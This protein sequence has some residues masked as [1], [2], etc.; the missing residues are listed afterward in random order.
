[1]NI[2]WVYPSF[3]LLIPLVLAL[4]LL[5]RHQHVRS[6]VARPKMKHLLASPSGVSKSVEPGTRARR[7]GGW[8]GLT[9]LCLAAVALARPQWG[10]TEQK[11][12][13]RSREV[14]IALDLS[15][16]MLATDVQPNR[17]DRAKLLVDSL[18]KELQGERIGLVVF[19]G[20][21]FVQCP[22][23]NDYE[24][25]RE[26]LKEVNPYF[27][28]QQGTDFGKLLQTAYK[29]FDFTSSSDRFLIVLSDGEDLAGDWEGQLKNYTDSKIH[30]ISLGVG[31]PGGSVIPEKNGGV[32]KDERGAV[33]LTRLDSRVLQE[34]ADKTSGRYVDAYR[35]VDLPKVL[36]ETVEQGEK[37]SFA[38]KNQVLKVERFQIPL[39]FALLFALLSLWRDFP[40]HPR[41]SIKKPSHLEKSLDRRL[42]R[43]ASS[44]PPIPAATA[45]LFLLALPLSLSA[46]QAPAQPAAGQ[47]APGEKLSGTVHTLAARDSLTPTDYAQLAEETI[48]YGKALQQ[49]KGNIEMGAVDDALLGV[50]E[51]EA[52]DAKAADWPRL[53]K[54]LEE[55]KKKASDQQKQKQDQQKQ[56]KQNKDKNQKQDQQKQNSGK[57]DQDKQNQQN[58]DPSQSDQNSG[59]E[60][61]DQNQKNQKDQESKNQDSKDQK[62]GQNGQDQQ[63]QDSQGQNRPEDE[64]D[65]NPNRN[66]NQEQGQDSKENKEKEDSK[67]QPKP[68][69]GSNEKKESQPETKKVGGGSSGQKAEK[70]EAPDAETAEMARKLD[71]IKEKDSPGKIY[72]LFSPQQ[73]SKEI[74]GKTW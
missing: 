69:S 51:G 41:H 47:P 46:Q 22:L 2:T 9:A 53:R 38:K 8:F 26:M 13:E 20:T 67:N 73:P 6:L 31:T 33:V 35:W 74:K 16:S 23:S 32:I 40:V 18:V 36:A 7:G 24:I 27:L 55:L 17:L 64:K 50:D 4:F 43:K 65:K 28:P 52:L 45:L 3:L 44:P 56:D 70:E 34:L 29:A 54:E 60:Q 48:G 10:E 30:I 12:Y 37:G 59:K 42:K 39:G 11:T 14:V 68:E 1:M 63:K 72:Q 62:S 15:R 71:Q 57:D 21:S 61:K 19:A 58:Q 5:R 66:Q 49:A 25:L